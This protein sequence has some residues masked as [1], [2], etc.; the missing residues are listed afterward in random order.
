MKKERNKCLIALL[1][2]DFGTTLHSDKPNDE[3]L[4]RLTGSPYWIAPE[5]ITL[6]N[7]RPYTNKVDIWALGI[8]ALE[9]AQVRPPHFDLEPSQAML[10]ISNESTPLP[11]LKEPALWSAEFADFIA[12][13]LQRDADR[14]ASAK[15][16]LEVKKKTQ[17][18]CQC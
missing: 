10:A 1:V 16:L 4:M 8:T 9:L 17:Y 5:M 14:R 18:V 11:R 7:Q 2:V 15:K 12:A 13:C 6:P 3:E